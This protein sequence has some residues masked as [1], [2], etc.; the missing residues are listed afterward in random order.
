MKYKKILFFFLLAISMLGLSSCLFGIDLNESSGFSASEKKKMQKNFDLILPYCEG[1]SYKLTDTY[2]DDFQLEYAIEGIKEEDYLKYL[3]SFNYYTFL[4]ERYDEKYEMEFKTFFHERTK[5]YIDT[6]YYKGSM[7]YKPQLF[8]YEYHRGYVNYYDSYYTNKG[9]PISALGDTINM[10][11]AT[12]STLADINGYNYFCPSTGDVKILV[13]PVDFSDKTKDSISFSISKIKQSLTDENLSRKS[14]KNYYAKS[15]FNKLN[16]S[17]E[18]ATSWYRAKNKSTYYN[19]SETI[20]ELVNDI[21]AYYDDKYNYTQFDSNKDGAIDGIILVHTLDSST[22]IDISWPATRNNVQMNENSERD[23]YDGV[24]AYRFFHINYDQIYVNAKIDTYTLIHEF[25]HLMGLDDYYD[26]NYTQR[27]FLPP[28]N[29]LDVMDETYCEHN[30]FSKLLLGWISEGKVINHSKTIELNDYIET[31]D[32]AIISNNFD[33]SYG[34]F[35]EFYII[36]YH[37]AESLTGKGR[38]GIVIY[39][40]D[41]CLYTY[42]S[43]T[44]IM[45][46][47]NDQSGEYSEQFNL[48]EFA[49]KDY[50]PYVIIGDGNATLNLVDNNKQNLSFSLTS[51]T[52]GQNKSKVDLTITIN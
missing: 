18:V 42:P 50:N 46:Y 44:T 26:T 35:Q 36:A 41:G 47:N 3:E 29:G 12:Y 51:K 27:T 45:N 37:V 40:V 13:V 14:L 34:P 21:L 38:Y 15:S 6:C 10:A 31:G 5:T 17:F 25:G 43:G 32:F 28:L 1:Y 19:D 8:V 33:P 48:I 7:L 16:L 30:P 4:G 49:N 11:D 22:D 52:K 9:N 24:F 23:K 20:S 39:H 2:D